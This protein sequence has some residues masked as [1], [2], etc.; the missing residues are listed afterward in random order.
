MSKD[1]Q[2]IE[3]IL[4]RL[5]QGQDSNTFFNKDKMIY[6][7]CAVIGWFAVQS[8]D[9]IKESIRGQ[10][11]NRE[12]IIALEKSMIETSGKMT[13]RIDTIE[14]TIDYSFKSMNEK[15]DG[16]VDRFNRLSNEPRLTK[17]DLDIEIE[18]VNDRIDYISE[19]M[20]MRDDRMIEAEKTMD[21][22]T[23]DNERIMRDMDAIK[24]NIGTEGKVNS[25]K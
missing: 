16:L 19:G 3:D 10:H 17:R 2:H 13:A 15:L 4:L 7:I 12:R 8:Y 21:K 18:P 20:R 1:T 9:D 11:L 24:I 22:I 5:Q 14:R 23:S 6:I 25:R